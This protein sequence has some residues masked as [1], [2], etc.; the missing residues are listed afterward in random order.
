M[1]GSTL[2]VI[3]AAT[4]Q[5][6]DEYGFDEERFLSLQQRVAA[7][8][9]SPDGNVIRGSIKPPPDQELLRL[10]RRGDA[11][12]ADT[13]ALGLDAL[14]RGEV[15]MA[16]LNGG[17]ATRFG[18][19]VKGIVEALDGRS[20]LEWKLAEAG[21]V[22]RAAGADIP[23]IV[24]NSFATDQATR[25]FLT[26][27]RG[28]LPEPWIISQ[29][30]SLRL[31]RDGSLYRDDQGRVSPYAPG[32]GDFA[33]AMRTS[34]TLERLRARGVRHVMLSNVDNLGAR[35]DPLVVGMH[36]Q[37]GRPMTVE[38]AAKEPGDAGG[39]P[40]RVDGRT[41]VVEGFRFPPD[42]DQSRIGVF[43]TNSFVFDLEA[44]DEQHRLTWFYVEKESDGDPVVQLERLVGE[45][46]SFTPAAYL[47]V[48]RTGPRGRFFPIK[49]PDDLVA[50]R[51]SLREM[52]AAPLTE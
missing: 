4:Q 32:H 21:R 44:L 48:P 22:A 52:L 13:Y 14:R 9:L 26:Q 11:G 51:A 34:G 19:V 20:F 25:A 28:D 33:D 5:I 40:A 50:S 36:R 2:G 39:S 12:W 43:N 30:V 7:G 38:V 31:N 35:I 37:S 10:P 16:V 29:F 18:G 42:F 27:R 45:L 1:I 15:A 24:M 41:I 23:C 6:L 8:D 3:D 46:S 17:M 49:T 47:Q